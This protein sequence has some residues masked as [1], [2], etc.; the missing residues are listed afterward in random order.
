[1][2]VDFSGCYFFNKMQDKKTKINDLLAKIYLMSYKEDVEV[3]TS[4]DNKLFTTNISNDWRFKD[5][6]YS[7][8]QKTGDK[9]NIYKFI[10]DKL[11]NLYDFVK[12]LMDV[13]ENERPEQIYV[14]EEYPWKFEIIKNGAPTFEDFQTETFRIFLGHVKNKFN[15]MTVEEIQDKQIEEL[16]FR[17]N[18]MMARKKKREAK[19][20]KKVEKR[21]YKYNEDGKVENI[22]K[23]RK[24][25]CEKEN[26]TKAALSMHLKGK[27]KQIKGYIYK[28]TKNC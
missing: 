26:I 14:D 21:I 22:Y 5:I 19:I 24:E 10:D 3:T 18:L 23:S 1:M 25:C 16:T 6:Y 2:A 20:K 28:E 11:Y 9:I 27:R 15:E 8:M 13:P 17:L 7:Y 4:I 12:M